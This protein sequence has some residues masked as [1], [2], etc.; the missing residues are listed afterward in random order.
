MRLINSDFFSELTAGAPGYDVIVSNPPYVDRQE[1]NALAAEFKHEPALGLAAGPHGLD[2]VLTI[3]HDAPRFL[4]DNGILIVEVGA[5]RAALERRFPDT[6]FVWLEF[7]MGG[8]GVFL[9][10][11][12]ELVRHQKRYDSAVHQPE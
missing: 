3:L 12:D 9:L 5:S 4:A 7:A 10:T 1:M 6:A 2:S 8:E 11:K